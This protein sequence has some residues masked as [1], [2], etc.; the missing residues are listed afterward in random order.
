MHTTHF[1][2]QHELAGRHHET[3]SEKILR[4]LAAC[5]IAATVWYLI[6]LYITT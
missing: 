4:F 3:V 5:A 6:M 2:H 1:H